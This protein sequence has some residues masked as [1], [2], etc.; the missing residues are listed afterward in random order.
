MQK[1]KKR[2]AYNNENSEN[3]YRKKLQMISDWNTFQEFLLEGFFFSASKEILILNNSNMD[4]S[5]AKY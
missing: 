4:I 2:T 5:Y 1:K 3:S